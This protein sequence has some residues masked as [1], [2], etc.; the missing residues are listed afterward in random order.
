VIDEKKFDVS[1]KKLE[2]LEFLGQNPIFLE[3]KPL[4]EEKKSNFLGKPILWKKD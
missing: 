1:Q 2:N 3:I 4:I